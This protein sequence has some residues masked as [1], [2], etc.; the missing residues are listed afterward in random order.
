MTVIDSHKSHL[1]DKVMDNIVIHENLPIRT[2]ANIGWAMRK[3]NPK[4][5]HAVNKYISNIKQGTLLGN[6]IYR[7][8]LERT[9]WLKKAL[10]PKNIKQFNQLSTLFEQYANKYQFDWLMIS[11]QAYQESKFN[12]R[13]ISHMG[14][15]GIMQVLPKTAKEPYVNIKNFRK[16]ENNIH[17][18]VKYM[19]FVHQRYFAKPEITKENQMYFSLA[20]YNAG[21]ANVR[22]MR[23]MAVKHGYDPNVWFNNVEIMAQKYVSK[24]PVRYVANISR[25]YVIYKQ[26]IQLQKL[27]KNQKGV[28]YKLF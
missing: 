10:N 14:A 2:G 22:K 12:N 8:Y 26:I 16:L 25:Y 17:A 11:A 3:N 18:G 15:V 20:A 6:I 7:R 5:K 27:R 9:A 23:K 24:E 21:P 28:K 13:L 4:L 19:N 1:W